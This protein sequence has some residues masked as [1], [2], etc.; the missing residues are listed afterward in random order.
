[1]DSYPFGQAAYVVTGWLNAA[2]MSVCFMGAVFQWMH[3]RRRRQDADDGPTDLLSL[4][5]FNSSFLGTFVAFV[6]G[7]SVQAFEHF[8]VWPRLASAVIYLMIIAEIHYDRR[9]PATRRSVITFGM[10]LAAGLLGMAMRE[11]VAR[12]L[13]GLSVAALIGVACMLAIGY[14]H[15]IQIVWR[16]G[17]TG[18]LSL[19]MNQ[20]I[21]MMDLSTLAFAL[22][23]GI[24]NAWPVALVSF[25][26][27]WT[28]L[29]ILW[30]F[31]WARVSPTAHARRSAM[32]DL[33]AQG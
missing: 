26:S 13:H 28:K 32:G 21:L 22:A 24:G 19:R 31:R 23:M 14:F 17:R 12:Y 2:L 9:N 29:C 25:V 20:F 11:D 16:H 27:L 3:I 18:A 6:F 1:M 30:L 33:S 4:R 5:Q 8:L 15:Q 7:Y 10:L